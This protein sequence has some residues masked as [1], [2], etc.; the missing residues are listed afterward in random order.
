ME[1]WNIIRYGREHK[2]ELPTTPRRRGLVNSY[3]LMMAVHYGRDLSIDSNNNYATFVD[4]H[5]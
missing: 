2:T 1:I 3:R 4:K 5:Y